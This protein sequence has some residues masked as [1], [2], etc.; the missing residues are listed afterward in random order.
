MTGR[1]RRKEGTWQQILPRA[2]RPP[3]SS[4]PPTAAA[5]SR[6]RDFKG[7]KLVLYFLPEGRHPRLHQRRRSPSPRSRAHSRRPTPT[8]S[9]YPPIRLRLRMPSRRSTSSRHRSASD[10]TH[11]DAGRLRRVGGEIHVWPDLHGHRP[12]HRPDRTRRSH[13]ADLAQGEG[14]RATPT[15]C[16]R[17]RRPSDLPSGFAEN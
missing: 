5:A 15:R 6:L 1:K 13:R 11:E 10:E 7:K 2:P 9:G 17:P 4:S 14:R 16:S 3:I 8:S 12:N